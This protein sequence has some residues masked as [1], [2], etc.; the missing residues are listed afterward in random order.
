MP[1]RIR[2]QILEHAPEE[3]RIRVRAQ[4]VG[5]LVEELRAG[6]FSQWMEVLN[7]GLDQRPEVELTTLQFDPGRAPNVVALFQHLVHERLKLSHVAVQCPYHP[8]SVRTAGLGNGVLQ[9]PAGKRD[10]VQWSAEIVRNKGE[11]LFAALL[12]FEGLLRS[13]SLDRNS[14]RLVKDPVQDVKCRAVQPDAI[15]LGEIVNA[16]TQDVVFRNDLDDVKT[17]LES[18]YAVQRRAAG[19]ERFRDRFVGHRLQCL[20]QLIEQCGNMIIQRR[21]VKVLP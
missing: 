16:A 4:I 1:D 5:D 12:N 14:D 3:T 2:R 6:S 20:G 18:L 21:R 15:A 19:K 11:I 10:R 8:G 17:I 13:K 9:D 7:Q